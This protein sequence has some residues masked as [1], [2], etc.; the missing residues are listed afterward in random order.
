MKEVPVTMSTTKTPERRIKKNLPTPENKPA[1]KAEAV[2]PERRV[3]SAAVAAEV[4]KGTAAAPPAETKRRSKVTEEALPVSATPETIPAT[5]KPDRKV[6]HAPE[7]PDGFNTAT[8]PK[9]FG[10]KAL[11]RPDLDRLTATLYTVDE[12]GPANLLKALRPLLAEDFPSKSKK[13]FADVRLGIIVRQFSSRYPAEYVEQ[14]P[15]DGKVYRLSVGDLVAFKVDEG[16]MIHLV[17]CMDNRPAVHT[18]ASPDMLGR[19]LP[20]PLDDAGFKSF[21][22]D[23]IATAASEGYKLEVETTLDAE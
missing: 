5:Q 20:I 23:L 10:R 1:P 14:N 7:T 3:K 16:S 11:M 18:P 4:K 17:P 21:V 8:N 22:Y 9:L 15:G 6:Q 2:K 12:V 13:W 19:V